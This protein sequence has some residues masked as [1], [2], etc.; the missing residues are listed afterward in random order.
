[1]NTGHVQDLIIKLFFF[2][3]GGGGGGGGGENGISVCPGP[4]ERFL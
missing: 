2:L 3:G 4:R 1:M